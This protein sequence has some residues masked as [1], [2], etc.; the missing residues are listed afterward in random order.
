MK[1][2][3]VQ[4]GMKAI[5]DLDKKEIDKKRNELEIETQKKNQKTQSI[6][7]KFGESTLDKIE[8]ELILYKID[9]I[10][11]IMI[12]MKIKVIKSEDYDQTI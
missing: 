11:E 9:L 10:S 6:K 12:K 7:D 4:A 8:E 2:S 3:V 5:V 1:A